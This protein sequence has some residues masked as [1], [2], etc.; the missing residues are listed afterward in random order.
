MTERLRASIRRPTRGKAPAAAGAD[1]EVGIGL[2]LWA[3][4]EV[5]RTSAG[6]RATGGTVLRA[7]WGGRPEGLPRPGARVRVALTTAGAWL[8][9]V[10]ADRPPEAELAAL[11]APRHALATAFV[12]WG[13]RRALLWAVL[14][15]EA[16]EARSA[17][18]AAGLTVES[19]EPPVL[20][21]AR[22]VPPE[23]AR[24][25]LWVHVGL[26]AGAL[27]A[28]TRDGLLYARELPGRLAWPGAGALH[29]LRRAVELAVSEAGL[30]GAG[31]RIV[32]AGRGLD[33]E[34]AAGLEAVWGTEV[35]VPED[36]ETAVARGVAVPGGPAAV[37]EDVPRARPTRVRGPGLHLGGFRAAAGTVGLLVGLGLA[38]AGLGGLW[39]ETH[40]TE[41][42]R[43]DILRELETLRPYEEKL[44]A[45]RRRRAEVERTI[46]ALEA[47]MARRP[48]ALRALVEVARRIPPEVWL[49][50]WEQDGD[51]FR[52]EGRAPGERAVA[53]FARALEAAARD[54]RIEEYRRD[55][56]DPSGGAV[57]RIAG[58]WK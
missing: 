36:P 8:R 20:A 21:L 44:E 15:A 33:D 41:V 46:R 2:I 3:P 14:A 55:P 18:R 7:D 4:A 52:L 56:R 54:V 51:A 6:S 10:P 50:A 31:L 19:L 38:A 1:V 24:P 29:P 32:A 47:L 45:L 26:G 30:G 57:F 39:W 11:P 58:V 9:D 34:V 42:R 53:E 17:C 48:R 40:S 49:E 12:P 28:A 22:L 35:E 43:A 16:A 23:P 5:L 25:T 37:L 27:L 13:P